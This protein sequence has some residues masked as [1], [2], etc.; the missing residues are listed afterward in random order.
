MWG[1]D[2]LMITA[3]C[4]TFILYISSFEYYGNSY[5]PGKTSDAQDIWSEILGSCEQCCTF[6]E[7]IKIQEILDQVAREV[8]SEM[9]RER[10]LWSL[11]EMNY[12]NMITFYETAI[13]EQKRQDRKSKD[14]LRRMEEAEAIYQQEQ[15]TLQEQQLDE[16]LSMV[17]E[18]N[19]KGDASGVLES[20]T[21]TKITMHRHGAVDE[22]IES[23][24]ARSEESSPVKSTSS[25]SNA[26]SA[27][28][29]SSSTAAAASAYDCELTDELVSDLLSCRRGD[30]VSESISS[31][32][33]AS[34]GS[35]RSQSKSEVSM[36]PGRQSDADEEEDE[37]EDDVTS[38]LLSFQKFLQW[39]FIK[40]ILNSS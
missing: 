33:G 32:R 30:S 24:L 8:E 19:A 18:A 26:M 27:P 31:K 37:E 3:L 12:E 34:Q 23:A 13:D 39:D 4:H 16:L 28:S 35:R 22:A 2:A 9:E 40:V 10:V 17:N 15:L 20:I 6:E 11:E 25:T 21:T 29:S 1:L 38:N 14:K 7:M 5:R 36:K